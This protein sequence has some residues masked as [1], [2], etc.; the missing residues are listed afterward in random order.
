[1]RHLPETSRWD[2][3]RLRGEHVKADTTES[4]SLG[5]SPLTRGAPSPALSALLSL[6]IIPAYAGSTLPE[7][8]I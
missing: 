7:G 1:M 6:R 8:S 2:H 3:P 4:Y 5:S